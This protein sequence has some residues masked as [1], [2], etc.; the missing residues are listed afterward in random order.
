[1]KGLKRVTWSRCRL[2]TAKAL[3]F[4]FYRLIFGFFGQYLNTFYILY[5][6]TL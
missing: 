5:L 1:M 3:T 2:I 4:G 6:V